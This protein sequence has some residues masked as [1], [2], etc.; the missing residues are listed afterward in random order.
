MS[1]PT[2]DKDS[3]LDERTVP[4]TPPGGDRYTPEMPVLPDTPEPISDWWDLLPQLGLRKR[5][6]KPVQLVPFPGKSP[7]A[8]GSI[9]EPQRL[10]MSS[11]GH[12]QE[13]LEPRP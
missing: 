2:P 3:H 4:A 5:R 12:R 6:F 10:Q 9:D 7:P 11:V 8:S 13:I 1:E